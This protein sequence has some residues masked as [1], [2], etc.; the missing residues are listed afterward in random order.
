MK[1]PLFLLIS[2]LMIMTEGFSQ[3]KTWSVGLFSFFDNVEFGGSGVKVPQTM[4]GVMVSPEAGLRWDTVHR[5]S[6]GMNLMHEF[7]SRTA[8]KNFYPLAYYEFSGESLTFK[9][10]AFPRNSITEKYPRLFSQDSL[11]YYRPNVEGISAELTREWGYIGLW[12]DWTGRQSTEVNETFFAGINAK[13]RENI[14]Y[15]IHS[16]YMFHFASKKEPVVEEALHD[17][18]LF[19][20]SIG[21]DLSGKTFLDKLDISA[22]WVAALERA[23]ADN[24]GWIKLHGM[25]LEARA[26]FRG[27]GL[28]STYY[29]G[30]RLLQFYGDHGNDLYWG[31]PAYR[32]GNYNRTDVYMKFFRNRMLDMEI[33]WSLHFL[34]STVYH[35]QMLKVKVNLSNL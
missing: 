31:D 23:R 30:D 18:M 6:I 24:T 12:L 29:S 34:E 1:K 28:F 17:N 9:M 22:G 15:L 32:S 35:E 19:L 7:G 14:F 3:D 11:Y 5:I 10:G 4:S 13:Y 16:G 33:T 21:I 2:F 26:E 20:T 27:I 25:L 8:I